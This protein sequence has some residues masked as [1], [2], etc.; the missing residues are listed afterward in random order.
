MEYPHLYDPG[1]PD[2]VVS[3]MDRP[4]VAGSSLCQ[5]ELVDPSSGQNTPFGAAGSLSDLNILAVTGLSS[6]R[7]T[8]FLATGFL[9][10]P[11]IP[12]ADS[13]PGRNTPFEAAGSLSYQAGAADSL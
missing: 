7:N 1:T 3:W 2:V 12:E 5:A 9:L 8:L 10:H 11:N 13:L 4:S 6:S